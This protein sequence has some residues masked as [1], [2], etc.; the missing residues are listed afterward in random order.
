M[1]RNNLN[2]FPNNGFSFLRW[3][4]KGSRLKSVVVYSVFF[5][6]TENV[7]FIIRKLVDTFTWKKLAAK[8]TFIHCCYMLYLSPIAEIKFENKWSRASHKILTFQNIKNC[9]KTGQ[10]IC[11]SKYTKPK[12]FPELL[13]VEP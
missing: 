3:K 12:S 8:E 4:K 11:Q 5:S 2:L 9:A 13:L 6:H 7:T 10:N 1:S